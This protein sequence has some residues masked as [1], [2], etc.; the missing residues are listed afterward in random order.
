MCHKLCETEDL[1][2]DS[3]T[4]YRG[5]KTVLFMS[6]RGCEDPAKTVQV[7]FKMKEALDER[8]KL[9]LTILLPDRTEEIMIQFEKT[10]TEMVKNSY[11]FKFSKDMSSAEDLLTLTWG[12][13]YRKFV[14]QNAGT[15]P[16]EKVVSLAA[17]S[18]WSL[19]EQH[20]YLISKLLQNKTFIP[21][22]YGTCGPAY[23]TEFTQSLGKYEYQFFSKMTQEW[24]TRAFLAVKLIDLIKQLDSDLHE[25]LNLC[26]LKSENFGLRNNWDV[27][28][29]DTD[30]A[31]FDTD[32]SRQFNYSKCVSNSDCDFFDCRGVCD[33]TAGKCLTQR[34][35]NNLQ[36][37]CP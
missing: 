33:T 23:V 10:F 27:T 20:E 2:F 16:R 28:L 7:V 34:A 35:N 17:Q 1:Q 13:D 4:N 9:D 3:C 24:E 30:C 6:C 37:W 25:T 21:N 26:D 12:W 5:G 15:L 22:I 36:V 14:E 11:W 31:L 32:L 19:S 8:D 29:I 18:I